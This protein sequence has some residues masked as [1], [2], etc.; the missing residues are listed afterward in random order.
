MNLS[1]WNRT[2][3]YLCGRNLCSPTQTCKFFELCFV[4]PKHSPKAIQASADLHWFV[5]INE[6]GYV[7][8]SPKF[9]TALFSKR[10]ISCTFKVP[11]YHLRVHQFNNSFKRFL[12][13]PWNKII[14]Y[15]ALLNKMNYCKRH[16]NYSRRFN[17]DGTNKWNRPVFIIP[18]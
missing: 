8:G 2:L 10:Q 12:L 5:P 6:S 13:I 1:T 3:C 9:R 4:K 16:T 7:L 15:E 17:L 11:R 14:R 18:A